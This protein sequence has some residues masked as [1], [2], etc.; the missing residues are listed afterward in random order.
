MNSKDGIFQI[1][2]NQ[3]TICTNFDV[4][5]KPGSLM[6]RKGYEDVGAFSPGATYQTDGLLSMYAHNYR[7]GRKELFAIGY[8]PIS[9]GAGIPARNWGRLYHSGN[10][11]LT[12]DSLIFNYCYT[13]ATWSWVSWKNNVVLSN[14]RQRPIIWN[15]KTARTLTIPAPG[16][17]QMVPFD[18]TGPLDGDYRYMI[19]LVTDS[20]LIDTSRSMKY[21]SYISDI[22]HADSENILLYNFPKPT[23]S[24]FW[25]YANLSGSDT[26][27]DSV[28]FYITRTKANDVELND[29]M[30]FYR[31]PNGDLDYF[32]VHKNDLDTFTFLDTMPDAFI[33]EPLNDLVINFG[34]MPDA[35]TQWY[36]SPKFGTPAVGVHTDTVHNIDSVNVILTSWG[37]SVAYWCYFATY[38]DSVHSIESDSGR[39]LTIATSHAANTAK[40]P[41]KIKLP[42]P[43]PGDSGLSVILYKGL[44]YRNVIRADTVLD[45]TDAARRY[46]RMRQMNMLSQN[47]AGPGAQSWMDASDAFNQKIA[48]GRYLGSLI[49]K[50]IKKKVNVV[51]DTLMLTAFFP[52]GSVKLGD[53]LYMLDTLAWDSISMRTPYYPALAPFGLKNIA[54]FRDRL[55]GSVGSMLYW[56]YLDSVGY[57]GQWDAIAFDLDDGDE[58][59]SI[60]PEGEYIGVSKNNS[61]YLAYPD[62]NGNYVPQNK[63]Y[64]SGRGCVAPQTPAWYNGS[65]ILLDKTG[66][67]IQSPSQYKDRG[68]TRQSLSYPISNMID[69][70][71]SELKDARGFVHKDKYYLSFPQKD[72]T[73]VF[74]LLTGGISI[75]TYAFTSAVHY[76]SVT[77]SGLVPSSAMLFCKTNDSLVYQ[78]DTTYQDNGVPVVATWQSG[79]LAISTDNN[80][81]DEFGLWT[82]NHNDSGTLYISFYN[83]DD[84]LLVTKSTLFTGQNIPR[85]SAYRMFLDK[86]NYYTVKLF[87]GNISNTAFDSLG[88][89]GL[90]L[91]FTPQGSR[92]RR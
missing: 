73:Y 54:Y 53:S 42:P 51:D 9:V 71:I 86:S 11:R 84:S 60:Q 32:T 76:D 28:K 90:D 30:F 13:G 63:W 80:K 59:T 16:S 74:D 7:D 65:L 24:L 85:F 66:L 29:S 46:I 81:L 83:A 56:S 72:T 82:G 89:Y 33:I 41:F 58:I 87:T 39:M 67:Y 68:S 35:D 47:W 48:R 18:S 36:A 43:P 92:M 22:V 15:G 27:P 5:E 34:T 45:T 14:G 78:G 4:G 62:A 70:P 25:Y 75:Y 10:K 61:Q 55:F 49:K 1:K 12:I 50:N 64:Q 77:N 40:L 21:C 88:I 2:P 44:M 23:N 19:R 37:D 31:I 52:V 6:K 91:W 20:T 17:I 57:W 38:F 69:Y 79:P 8:A 3:G 26:I